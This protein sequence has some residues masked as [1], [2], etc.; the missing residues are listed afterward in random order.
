MRVL[1]V[2]DHHLLR[3]GLREVVEEEFPHA[4]FGEAENSQTALALVH[5]R[6]WDL[7]LLDINIPGRNGLEVLEEIKHVSPKLP[8]LVIS[9]YSEA[10][11]AVRAL[12]LRAA[13]Y[14][15]KNCIAE[16]LLA[17][18]R[19]ALAGGHYVTVELAEKLAQSLGTDL[20]GPRHESLSNRELQI[21]RMVARGRNIKEIAAELCLS[22][23]TV[24]TY[25]QRI[26]NKMGFSTNVELARYALQS[27]LTD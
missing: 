23:K 16:E 4:E 20:K 15:T 21:L 18:I 2:D 8:V 17:A 22:R 24:G 13:G 6:Q 11:F 10:D 14:L 7:V 5:E 1:I 27:G 26:A 9:A 19:K 3:R 12:K 25:R